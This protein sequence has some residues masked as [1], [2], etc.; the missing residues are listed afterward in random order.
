MMDYNWD[1]K[2]NETYIPKLT[3]FDVLSATESKLRLVGHEER[4]HIELC[5]PRNYQKEGEQLDGHSSGHRL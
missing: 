1:V 4:R 3:L 2:P 5:R